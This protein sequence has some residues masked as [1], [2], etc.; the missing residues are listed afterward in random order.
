MK[1]DPMQ[2]SEVLFVLLTKI[3]YIML[4]IATA[5]CIF[6]AF[7]YHSLGKAISVSALALSVDWWV[8]RTKGETNKVKRL[9]DLAAMM[10]FFVFGKISLLIE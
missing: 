5:S 1:K 8:Y 6:Q 3:S 4:A 9:I 2:G 10:I 7:S